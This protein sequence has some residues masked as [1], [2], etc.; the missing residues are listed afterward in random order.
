V[1]AAIAV[2]VYTLFCFLSFSF[3]HFFLFFFLLL[4][5][6]Q[7]AAAVVNAKNVVGADR[8]LASRVTRGSRDFY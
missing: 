7:A 8:R 1:L 4:V 5:G 3:N 2:V 6:F